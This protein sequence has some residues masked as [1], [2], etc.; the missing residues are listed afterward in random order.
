MSKKPPKKRAL[1][2]A[3]SVK[4]RSQARAEPPREAKI[5]V[6]ARGVLIR[7]GK[8]LLCQNTK[9]RYC[10]LPGGH[11][12]FS[13]SATAALAREFLEETGARIGVGG[14]AL[15]TEGVF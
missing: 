9:H 5:E 6:I 12:E 2:S 1:S 14:L 7:G 3:S 4:K 8:V 15:V 13:E 11:V 10:Y